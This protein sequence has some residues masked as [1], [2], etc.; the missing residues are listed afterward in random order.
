MKMKVNNGLVMPVGARGAKVVALGGGHGL[1]ASLAALKYLTRNITAIVT[2]ADDGGSSGRLRQELGGLPPGDL[3]MALSALCDDSE[4]GQTWRDLL[5][6][7]FR[8]DGELNGHALGNLL[9]EGLWDLLGDAVE[10]LDWVGRLLD[11]K[12][13][14]IP[15][16]AV[17]LE[18]EADVRCTDG[19]VR[20]VHGQNS[21]AKAR[22]EILGI[23]ISPSD[24][25][26]RS[27]ALEAIE[28]AQWV[29]FGPGSWFT[30][31]LP[32][33]LVP[34][35]RQAIERTHAKK[36]LVLNLQSDAETAAYDAARHVHSFHE[37]APQLA[38]DTIVVDPG[39]VNHWDAL[40][41]AAALCGAKVMAHPVA[42]S[43]LPGVHD[44]LFL[45][46]AYRRVFMG[47]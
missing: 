42:H 9:I 32:H 33:V 15:M 18:I 30:S 28:D 26:V 6:Y 41:E 11:T 46:A 44:P 24:P 35:L 29:I 38:L 20:L 1:Y 21:V 5:Q 17:P 3:R 47:A 8:S 40:H 4:W 37:C 22:G 34:Q 13:R 10:G 19:I 23:H 27:E 39:S 12:G 25:P 14:V 45:A 36:I 16:A 31:V 2:V 7:R 43:A